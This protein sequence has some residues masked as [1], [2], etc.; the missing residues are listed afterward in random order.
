MMHDLMRFRLSDMVECEAALRRLGVGATSMEEVAGRIV[1]WLYHN[2]GDS[3]AAG[4]ACA[5]VRFFK[6]HP[7]EALPPTLQAFA[8]RML[9]DKPQDPTVRCLTL[10]AT[11]GERAEWNSRERSIGH[12]AIPLPSEDI[13]ARA[14]MISRLIYQLGLEIHT[15]IRPEPSIL[16]DHEQRT[17]NVFHVAEA[18]GSPHIPAQEE[19]VQPYRIRSVLGFG[20][21]LA[22]GDLF[23]VIMFSRTPIGSAVADMFRTVA[24]AA[25]VAVVPFAAGPIFADPSS[26]PTRT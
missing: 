3:V 15:V 26:T 21:L 23:A 7:F 5:L 8:R 6:T 18:T 2:L 19:F 20:G 1:H 16:I 12:Q 11:V 10:L 9:V 25:K 24:L 22:G 14:P 13:V 4:R 17:F